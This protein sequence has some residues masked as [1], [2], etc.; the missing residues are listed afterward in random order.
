MVKA[1]CSPIWAL[2]YGILC[3]ASGILDPYRY[4]MGIRCQ[5]I[6]PAAQYSPDNLAVYSCSISDPSYL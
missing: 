1:V 5:F 3:S 4:A 2:V 6:A